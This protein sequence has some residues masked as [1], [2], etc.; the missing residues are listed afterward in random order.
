MKTLGINFGALCPSIEKQLNEQGLHTEI[1]SRPLIQ[2]C[3][4]A[5]VLLSI[6]DI[7]SDGERDKA[8]KRMMNLIKR[9]LTNQ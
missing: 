6:H 5:I 4:D 8:R 3:A 7:L 2:S 9:T 1:K